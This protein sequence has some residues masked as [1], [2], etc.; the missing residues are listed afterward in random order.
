[1]ET[2]EKQALFWDVNLAQLD[3]EEHKNFIAKRILSMGDIDDLHWAIKA[4]SVDFLRNIFLKSASLLDARSRNFWGIYFNLSAETVCIL[5]RST[6]KRS[7][8]LKR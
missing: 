1:M 8:F 6:D 4:Y 5:K 7:V 3:A 2:L